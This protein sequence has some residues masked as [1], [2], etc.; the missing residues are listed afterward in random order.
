MLSAANLNEFFVH[1][2]DVR[3]ANGY[4]P[5]TRIRPRWMR[6]LWRNVSPAPWFLAR[7]LRGA[8]LEHEWAGTANTVRARRGE[9]TVRVAGLPGELLLYLF[10]RQPIMW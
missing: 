6:P 8:G 5:R 1:H 4:G 10:G 2:E 3:R 9:P 7:R